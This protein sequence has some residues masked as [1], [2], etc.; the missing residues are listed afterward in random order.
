[1]SLF[2]SLSS[3]CFVAVG[4]YKVFTAEMRH[5]LI[6]AARLS[7]LR[8]ARI[9]FHPHDASPVQE[10]IIA[11]C[12]DTTLSIHKHTGKSESFNVMEGRVLIGLYGQDGQILD[13]VDLNG[14]VGP[15]YYRMDCGIPHLVSPLS[16]IVIIHETTVGPFDRERHYEYP[17]WAAG[18][19]LSAHRLELQR[20]ANLRDTVA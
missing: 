10:M 9:N 16:D 2:T 12:R 5:Q 17:A 1:M 14:D 3:S 13:V 18:I 7:S 4:D 8:R 11:M 20:Q 15:R 19:D 6:A